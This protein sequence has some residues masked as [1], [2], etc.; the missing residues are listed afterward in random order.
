M[1]PSTDWPE[2]VGQY[3]RLVFKTV[4]DSV[5]SS[6]VEDVVQTTLERAL[7]ASPVC[8]TPGHG[9]NYLKTLARNAAVDYWRSQASR[10]AAEGESTR[11]HDDS[12]A[13]VVEARSLIRQLRTVSDKRAPTVLLLFAAGYS[14]EEVAERVGCTANAAYCIAHRAR[15]EL[16]Q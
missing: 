13:A 7:R 16:E 11:T 9:V 10:Q 15:R 2:F 12:L 8:P 14:G 1:T 5:P 4:I 3:R 6:D